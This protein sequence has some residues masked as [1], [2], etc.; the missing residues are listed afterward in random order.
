MKAA[1]LGLL[2]VAF[3]AIPVNAATLV[4]EGQLLIPCGP[5]PYT[6]PRHGSCGPQPVQLSQIVVQITENRAP[7][8]GTGFFS[9][10][11]TVNISGGLLIAGQY[12]R[13]Q[14]MSVD[15]ETIYIHRDTYD[16]YVARGT[17]NRISGRIG[18]DE[19]GKD[20]TL[21]AWKFRGTCERRE[22]LF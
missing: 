13:W 7:P 18:I 21:D 22:R 10:C 2:A 6:L 20:A 14:G 15:D 5:N 3:V 8:C 11:G 9:S 1:A 17:I 12:V 16:E 4:C 19:L